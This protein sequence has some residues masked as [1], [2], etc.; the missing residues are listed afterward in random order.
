MHAHRPLRI[1]R[2]A[3]AA[4]IDALAQITEPGRPW[5]RRSFSPRFLQG[6]AWLAG[7]FAEA[8]LETR[9]D[10]AGNLIGRWSAN[11]PHAAVLMTGSHSD[12]VPD[13]GRFDGIAGVLAGLA[14][15]RAL[16]AAGYDPVHTFELV[17][18]L[19]EEP[20]EWALSCIGSRGMAGALSAKDL[21]SLGP[22]GESLAAAIDRVGG[23]IARL[24]SARRDDILAFVE[25]HIEQG[26]VLEAEGDDIG[27]V[28]GIA[29]IGRVRARFE[30]VAGH[31]GTQPMHMRADAGLALSRFM[32]ALRDAA[33]A[34]IG[35]GH[36][37]ATVGVAKLEPGGA[38]VVPG[39]AEAIVDIRAEDDGAMAGFIEHL[40]I[41]AGEAAAAEGCRVA[42]LTEI[43]RTRA[44]ACDAALRDTI[45]AAASSVSAT[46]RPLASGA[47]H[48]AAFMARIAPSAMLFVPSRDGASHCP[49]EWTDPEALALG[50]DVLLNALILRDQAPAGADLN[51]LPKGRQS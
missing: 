42:A 29:G 13:G 12:T 37:T 10:A 38:N 27:I 34:V 4:D 40:A 18:F 19:A 30:G 49:E 7:R 47:G 32:L 2:A 3:F 41:I 16:R 36:F 8:G 20:S 35:V 21:A 50:A 6:R 5:T 44:V 45:A 9:I 14:A 17:D 24:D 43:S 11:N 51:R 1:D 22:A 31:A 48:D 23:S 28:S 25:L 46:T 39:A 33:R 15:I 26:P